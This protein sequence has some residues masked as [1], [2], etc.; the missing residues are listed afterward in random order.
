M[1]KQVFDK[2]GQHIGHFDGEFFYTT[3]KT[4]IRVD[5]SEVYSLSNGAY[6]GELDGDNIIDFSGSVMYQIKP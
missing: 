1:H 5:G 2:N 6:I 4:D 3:P